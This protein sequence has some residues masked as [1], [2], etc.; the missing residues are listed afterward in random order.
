MTINEQPF[1]VLLDNISFWLYN[2]QNE[3][4]IFLHGYANHTRIMDHAKKERVEP[5]DSLL[6]PVQSTANDA[7]EVHDHASA[8]RLPI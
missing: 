3:A 6:C 1:V 5:N 8:L 2:L 4:K 7:A